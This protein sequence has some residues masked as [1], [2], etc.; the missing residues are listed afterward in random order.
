MTSHVYPGVDPRIAEA[1]ERENGFPLAGHLLVLGLV[2]SHSHGT[3]IPKEADDGIDDVDYMGIVVPPARHLLGL[4]EWEHWVWQ[5]EELDVVLYS[6][7]KAVTL[8][9]K[10]NPNILG[11][12]WLDEYREVSREGSWL[13]A[14]R[15]V[16]ASASNVY[17]AFVGYA[18]NQLQKMTTFSEERASEYERAREA[19]IAIGVEPEDVLRASGGVDQI[20]AQPVVIAGRRISDTEVVHTLVRF[21]SL[22]R[23]FFSGYMGEKRRAMVR[24]YGYDVKNASHLI[25]LLRTGIEYLRTGVMHVRR[26]DAEE[27]IAIKRGEWPLA[28]V[29]AE[30]SCL[31]D[32]AKRAFDESPLPNLPDLDRAEMV[33]IE[34]HRRAVQNGVL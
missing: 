2:G 30:A 32:D 13:M 12:L 9:L 3:Y 19:V 1:F 28:R 10:G 6:M 18:T 14:N 26:P 5:S 24:R 21:R 11:L 4:K 15:G 29:Q 16:F 33:L 17:D 27:L 22:H 23:K 20:L 31:F 7:R 25:R 34:I 8:M